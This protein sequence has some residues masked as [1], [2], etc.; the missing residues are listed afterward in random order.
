MPDVLKPDAVRDVL[1]YDQ[2]GHIVVLTLNDPATRNALTGDPMFAGFEQAVERMN[3]DLSVRAA[4][5]TGEGTAFCSGGNVADMR[6]KKGMFGG[7][8][9]QIE[10]QYR[11]GIQ[12]IPRALFKLDVP[13]IAAVNGPAIGAGCDLACMCDIR[14]ASEKALFAESFVKVGIIAG[15]GGSWLLPRIVGVSRASELA[16]TGDTIDAKAALEIGLVSRV[17]VPEELMKESTALAERIA[18]NP[19]QVVRWTKRMIRES[20]HSRLETILDM[21]ASYQ[22]LAHHTADHTEAVA[23][24]FEKRAPKFTGK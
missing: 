9:Q 13:L 11:A 10:A 20:Q 21:C 14:I 22:S 1:K 7:T 16:F 19:P 8:P 18:K 15:D 4:I 17:V 6:D 12:R 2:H 24:M 3:T 5:L 23:S